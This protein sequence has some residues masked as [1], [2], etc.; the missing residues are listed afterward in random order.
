MKKIYTSNYARQRNNPLA[1][2]ISV[3]APDWYNGKTLPLLA[4]TWDLV[5]DI[6]HGV[7]DNTEY[8]KRYL[9]LIDERNKNQEV[10]NLITS[11]PDQSFLL[12]YEKPNDYCHRHTLAIWV[13]TNLSIDMEEWK[14]KKEVK[15]ELQQTAVDSF[16]DF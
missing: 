3:K 15:E 7:I 14:N 10:S 11:L 6:K 16:L 5:M 1:Y 12:C 13:V 9:D 8:E 4:P 2:A